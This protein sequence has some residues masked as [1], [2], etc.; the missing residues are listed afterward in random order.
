MPLQ[1]AAKGGLRDEV[2]TPAEEAEWRKLAEG[3]YPTIRG[4][5]V[6]ADMY[7]RV[8]QLLAQYRR[9]GGGK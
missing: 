1:Q 6:P 4:G 8:Q 2:A 5:I 7:D 3:V 9:P